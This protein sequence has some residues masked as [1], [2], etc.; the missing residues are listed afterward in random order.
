MLDSLCEAYEIPEQII[1]VNGSRKIV[2]NW[3][4]NYEQVELPCIQG[5]WHKEIQIFLHMEGP[6]SD[7]LFSVWK[8][9]CIFLEFA[10]ISG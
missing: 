2:H 7:L 8:Y 5:S 9:K 1:Y 4:F 10:M 3:I 6:V